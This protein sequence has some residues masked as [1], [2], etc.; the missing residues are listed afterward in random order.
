MTSP[1]RHH[2]VP[3]FL[4]DR[5]CDPAGRLTGYRRNDDGTFSPLNTIPKETA[6]EGHLYALEHVPNDLRQVI[7]TGFFR[8]QIDTP[9]APILEKMLAT[10]IRSLSRIERETWSM[11]LIAARARTPE[12]VHQARRRGRELAEQALLTGQDEFLALRGEAPEATL[13]EWAQN[14]HPDRVANAG[15]RVLPEVISKPE[16]VLEFADMSWLL[17]DLSRASVPVVISDRPAIVTAGIDSESFAFALPVG[18]AHVFVAAKRDSILSGLLRRRPSLLAR[19]INESSMTQAR[20]CVYGQV[21]LGF[22]RKRFGKAYA[23][24]PSKPR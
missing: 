5:W 9:S 15:I 1:K 12:W 19:E 24:D 2:Y 14:H 10:G 18:P 22:V 11:F 13:L 7:E 21:D 23:D 4:L 8:D 17:L 6:A 3:Q 16:R 20:R